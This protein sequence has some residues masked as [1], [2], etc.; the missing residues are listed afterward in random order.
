MPWDDISKNT[1][2]DCTVNIIT[3]TLLLPAFLVQWKEPAFGVG[4][5]V[6]F[7]YSH[8]HI[9]IEYKA[10]RKDATSVWLN[11]LI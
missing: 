4:T 6:N 3:A 7:I 9:H 10:D 2:T 8:R 11:Y 5:Y 1:L